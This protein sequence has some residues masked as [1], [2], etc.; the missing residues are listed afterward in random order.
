MTGIMMVSVGNSYGSPPVNT[1]A[2]SVSGSTYVGSVLTCSTGTWTGAPTPTYTYQWKRAG[3]NISGATSSSYTSKAADVGN[4]V[5]CTVTATNAAGAASANSSNS[6]TVAYPAIGASY[7][8]GYFA[9]YISTTA[10]GVATHLLVVAPKATGENSS[11]YYR[12]PVDADS[13]TSSEIDGP[14]NTNN[15]NNSAH[16]AAQFC[17][18][19]NIGGFTDWY[20]PAKNEIDVLYYSFKPNSTSNITSG[21]STANPN[22]VPKRTSN[23]TSGDPAQTSV[24]AFQSGGAEEFYT[25]SSN[26][27]YYWSSTQYDGWTLSAWTKNFNNGN[28]NIIYKENLYYVRAVRRIAL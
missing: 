21:D 10:N 9:G 5:S 28:V 18:G 3:S 19:L 26:S 2:P 24:A 20:L 27:T 4:A 11:K 8:G 1:V 13:G 15:I 22:S 12:T 25:G 6:I 7:G 23:Y 16:P 17:K 14:T